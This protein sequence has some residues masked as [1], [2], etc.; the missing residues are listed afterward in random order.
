MSFDSLALGEKL[1]KYREQFQ[2][3]FDELSNAT[4]ISL[5]SLKEFENG[6]K[7]P[8]GDEILI[9]ADFYK[10]DYKFFISNEKVATFE[11]TETL[12][13]RYGSEFSKTDRWAVQ[14]VLYLAD[15]EE[16]LIEALGLTKKEEFSFKKIGNYYKGHGIKAA[17]ELRKFLNY[18]DYE[19]PM[20]VYQDFRNTGIHVFRRWLENSEISGLFVNHPVAG[21]CILINYSEDIYRQRFTAAHEAAHA[22]FDTD[23]DVIV[24]FTKWD[25]RDLAET[26]ANTFASHYL[27]PPEFLKKIP[28][29]KMWNK[30]KAIKW[31]NKFK[32]ST[33]AF[34]YALRGQNLIDDQKVEEIKSVKVPQELKIDPELSNTLSPK[35][36]KRKTELLKL[37]LS[38]YYVNLCFE[39]YRRDVISSSRIAEMLLTDKNHLKEITRLY[40]EELEYGS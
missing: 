8:T 10:C 17:K 21:K 40:G 29:S 3:S 25:R 18:R 23:K 4:G 5:E 31:A 38:S 7:L 28:D 9:F 12:F 11:Q 19:V 30:E 24:S 1:K 35:N 22:I 34:S 14:E 13:R 27:M 2:L 15:C 36:K 16:F 26:R 33:E 39:A 32:V 20:D 37:G 6:E